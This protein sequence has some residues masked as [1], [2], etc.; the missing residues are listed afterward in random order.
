MTTSR[1]VSEDELLQF[2]AR[3]DACADR[4]HDRADPT[5]S[6]TRAVELGR[7]SAYRGAATELRA[8]IRAH[9]VEVVG[10]VPETAAG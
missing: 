4:A 8:L 2:C 9:A 5:C 3:L 6:I 10:S 7:E 1:Q